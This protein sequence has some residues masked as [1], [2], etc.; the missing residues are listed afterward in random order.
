MIDRLDFFIDR[1]LYHID[2]N[3]NNDVVSAIR[4]AQIDLDD[5][6]ERTRNGI[7][8]DINFT[9]DIHKF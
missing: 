4:Y 9:N 3:C 8:M 2:S 5:L 1:L 7:I 6:N